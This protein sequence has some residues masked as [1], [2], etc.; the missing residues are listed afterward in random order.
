M[1]DW[2]PEE[3]QKH[4]EQ[5]DTIFLKLWKKGCGACKLS[6]PAIER[7]EAEFDSGLVFGQISTDDHPGMLEASGTEVLPAFFIFKNRREA[8]RVTGFKGLEKLRSFV[9]ESLAG[10]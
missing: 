5:G 9:S 10:S 3:L 8:G 2:T 7:I 1:K 4:L 6:I